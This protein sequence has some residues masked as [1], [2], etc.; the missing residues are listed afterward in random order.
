[1]KNIS[2]LVNTLKSGGAE[3]QSVFLANS[4]SEDY[5]VYFVL[6]HGKLY[7]ESLLSQ[8]SKEVKLIQLEGSVISTLFQLIKILKTN[9]INCIFTFLTKP[10]V[11][12]AIAGKMAKVEKIYC[13]IRTQ[14]LPKW[15]LFLEKQVSNRFSTKIIFNNVS[16]MEHMAKLG[17]SNSVYIPNCISRIQ[18]PISRERKEIINIISVGR[19]VREKDFTT[20][21]KSF[22]QLK[23]YKN[24]RFTI[25]GYGNLEQEIRDCADQS[26]MKDWIN[27]LINPDNIPEL[28]NQADIYLSTSL[29]EGTSNSILEAMNA[30]L[31]I[32]ATN[33]GDN[34]KLVEQ[35]VNG[36]L[37]GIGDVECI[38]EKMLLLVNDFELLNRLGLKSNEILNNN[39]SESIFK[40]NY[41]ELIEAQWK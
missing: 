37:C 6:L 19:F 9:K 26:V 32:I 23:D 29:F 8:L 13:G 38:S 14:F 17:I 18:Q 39:F 4:L 35:G 12:G 20:A 27:I 22:E 11:I 3:K 31:P 1:M 5:N 28:L 40:E 34:F 10:N 30:S 25:V 2:I 33:V 21:I 15:K 24:V 16:G 7:D 36:F 41:T